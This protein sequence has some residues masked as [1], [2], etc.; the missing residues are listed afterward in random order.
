MKRFIIVCS[1]VFLTSCATNFNPSHY[2]IGD[3]YE[4][5]NVSGNAL[6]LFPKTDALYASQYIP[7]EIVEIAWNDNYILAKQTEQTDDPNNPD[8]SITNQATE[9]YWIIDLKNNRRFG[10]YTKKQFEEQK[11]EF[12]LPEQLQL[13]SV[14][15]YLTK[16]KQ[17]S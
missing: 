17:Q 2:N 11:Q 5:I 14:K 9:N 1:L 12:R 10:P 16:E 6:E 3:E 7:P 4:L 15:T 8:A 13:Q